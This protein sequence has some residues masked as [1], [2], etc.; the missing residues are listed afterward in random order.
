MIFIGW[1][2]KKNSWSVFHNGSM[3]KVVCKS[4]YISLFYF[5]RFVVRKKWYLIA[6][7]SRRRLTEEELKEL[8]PSKTPR[9]GLWESYSISFALMMIAV[10][11][12]ASQVGPF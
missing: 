8:F 9:L 2:D 5:F 10:F 1:G 7:S 6:K 4:T 11:V 12:Y 3:K